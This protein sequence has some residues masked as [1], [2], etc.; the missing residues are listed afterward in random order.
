M[1]DK[2]SSLNVLVADDHFG[3]A[4]MTSDVLQFLGCSTRIAAGG[5]ESI[6][7]AVAERPDV[8][9]M[10]VRMPDLDGHAAAKRIKTLLPEVLIVAMSGSVIDKPQ[11]VG[12]VVVFDALLQKPFTPTDVRGVLSSRGLRS[13][14]Q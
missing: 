6:R 8:I 5:E 1:T 10:D 14:E 3:S 2:Q 4:H 9:F 12:D 7:I 13:G 11:S